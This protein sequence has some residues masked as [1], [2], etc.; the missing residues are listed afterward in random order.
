[1]FL[2]VFIFFILFYNT[3]QSEMRSRGEEVACSLVPCIYLK[4]G[5]FYNIFWNVALLELSGRV[6]PCSQK[7]STI[8]LITSLIFVFSVLFKCW[9]LYPT[10]V[11]LKYMSFPLFPKP[12][13]PQEHPCVLFVLYGC[14]LSCTPDKGI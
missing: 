8:C 5:V 12:L 14:S 10:I 4:T 2:L 7:T 6:L 3:I 13:G 11:P 1:M 9:P